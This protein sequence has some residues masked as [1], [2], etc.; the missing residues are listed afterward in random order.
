M[1]AGYKRPTW[2]EPNLSPEE[3][4]MITEDLVAERIAT[5]SYRE[6][7]TYVGTDDPTA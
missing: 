2:G 3:V 7:V 5:D 1:T 6:M 4:G